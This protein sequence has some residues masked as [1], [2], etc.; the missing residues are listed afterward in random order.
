MRIGSSLPSPA[1]PANRLTVPATFFRACV[2]VDQTALHRDWRYRAPHGLGYRAGVVSTVTFMHRLEDVEALERRLREE[3]L[4]ANLSGTTVTSADGRFQVLRVLDH[5]ASSVVCEALDTKLNRRVALK[6]FPGLADDRLARG[7][8]REAQ[9]LAGVSHPNIVIVHDFD[10]LKL[11]PGEHRCFFVAMELGVPLKKWLEEAP[12]SHEEILATFRRVGEGLAAIHAAGFVYRDFKPGNVVLVAGVPKI[13]DF[14]L[15]LSAAA[16]GDARRARVGTP[17]FMSPEALAGRPQDPRSDQ[18]SFAAALWKALC[19]ALPY[20]PSSEDPA[21][22]R[23]LHPPKAPLPEPVLEALRRALDPVPE[24]RFP[25]MP[26]LL[27][28]LPSLDPGRSTSATGPAMAVGID[29][30]ATTELAPVRPPARRSLAPWLAFPVV[31]ALSVGGVLAAMGFWDTPQATEEE[32]SEGEAPEARES[33]VAQPSGAECPDVDALTGSWRFSAV[34]EWAEQS[35]HLGRVGRYTLELTRDGSPCGLWVDLRKLG[36]D[37][38]VYSQPRSD[39]QRVDVVWSPPFTGGFSGRFN[40]RKAGEAA[41]AHTYEFSFIIDGD[42]LYG[43][44]H[45]EAAGGK[46]RFAGVIRGAR[47]SAKDAPADGPLPCSALCGARCLGAE[48]AAECRQACTS[49]A[50]AAHTCPAPDPTVTI[51]LPAKT[52]ACRDAKAYAGRWLFLA[53]DRASR[54][55]RAYE[56]ELRVAGCDLVVASAQDSDRAAVPFEGKGH[57]DGSGLWQLELTSGRS[58]RERVRHVWSLVG[59][60]PAFGEFTAHHGQERLA[61]GVLAAYRRP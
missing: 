15:A 20:D 27:A 23:P 60:D 13:V 42:R 28:A 22:R 12:R 21:Q 5:G 24:R 52:G 44:F 18:F 37:D 8:K 30:D 47:A 41:S 38:I 4:T 54:E 32:V 11:M 57:V 9:G 56:V 43:D 35:G 16:G 34:A 7:V 49:D 14:G 46:Q 50:W 61:A 29:I 51:G 26:A 2:L 55:Q 31:G 39:R 33:P 10:V 58:A 53:R 59:R 6:L 25:D 1:R 19:G 36:N 40:P 48:A 45:A 3:V 17:A